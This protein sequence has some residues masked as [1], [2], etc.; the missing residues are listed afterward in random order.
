M[1]RYFYN[2]T[3]AV[4]FKS[5]LIGYDVKPAY[6]YIDYPRIDFDDES[7]ELKFFN[8]TRR[9]YAPPLTASSTVKENKTGLAYT[10]CFGNGVCNFY[11][12]NS[13]RAVYVDGQFIRIENVNTTTVPPTPPPP[14]VTPTP[15]NPSETVSVYVNKTGPKRQVYDPNQGGVKKYKETKQSDDTIAAKSGPSEPLCKGRNQMI[16]MADTRIDSSIYL[17]RRDLQMRVT[18]DVTARTASLS[19]TAATF[20]GALQLIAYSAA[21]LMTAFAFI[22]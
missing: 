17:R 8:G 12:R 19:V 5:Q 20:T 1:K 11:Y 10:D 22:F 16:I 2:G 9:W 14:T 4:Y 3:I 6:M 13:T 7:Y 18:D 15:T 21:V